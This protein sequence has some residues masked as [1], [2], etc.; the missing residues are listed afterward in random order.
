MSSHKEAT[1]CSHQLTFLPLRLIPN[2]LFPRERIIHKPLDLTEPNAS[3]A[4]LIVPPVRFLLLTHD[5][6]SHRYPLWKIPL[7]LS[8]LQLAPSGG[9]VRFLP[10]LMV[11]LSRRPLLLGHACT[12]ANLCGPA[13][14][15]SHP[16]LVQVHKHMK[17]NLNH[18]LERNFLTMFLSLSLSHFHGVLPQSFN[19]ALSSELYSTK[20]KAFNYSSKVYIIRAI[21]IAGHPA[22]VCPFCLS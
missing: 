10:K 22:H 20:P 7:M 16:W 18:I 4:S 19:S 11:T 6:W 1:L 15:D 12:T 5:R 9:R 17:L 2:G 21:I 3:P 14:P 13:L 8:S